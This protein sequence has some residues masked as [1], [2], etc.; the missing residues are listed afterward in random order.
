MKNRTCASIF[1]LIAFLLSACQGGTPTAAPMPVFTKM[2]FPTD[3]PSATAVPILR[4]GSGN[5][6]VT[7]IFINHTTETLKI[8]WVN[9]DGGEDAYGEV[10]PASSQ[11]NDTYNTH[12]WRVRD[13]AGNLIGEVIAS[14]DKVQAFQ[15]DADK[16]FSA[17]TYNPCKLP[18]AAATNVALGFPKMADRLRST[19]SVN[20][21]VLFVDFSD[22]QAKGKPEELFAM[23]SPGA[24]K[25]YKDISYGRMNLVLEPH[26]AW[27]R[28]SQ[29]SAH[30]GEGLNSAEG[31]QTFIQEAVDLADSEVDFS[32]ADS[33]LVMAPPQAEALTKGPAFAGSPDFGIHADGVVLANAVTSGS[34]LSFWGFLWLNHEMGHSMSLVDLYDYNWNTP[35]YEDL[36]KFVGNFGLMDAIDGKSPEY[37]A[38]ERWQ[39]GWLDDDQIACQLTNDATTTLSPIETAGNIKAVMIPVSE[40][41]VVV[42]ES[43]R[44]LGYDK[45]IVKP[46]AL[47]YTVDTS[48][49]SGQGPIVV[50]PILDSDPHRDKSPLAVGESA[51]V[52]GVTVTVLEATDNSDTVQVTVSR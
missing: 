37:F 39:L 41:K 45:A 52:D 34:D 17:T 2:P 12:V 23:V 11:Q 43:R 22:V 50:Y 15:I 6:A 4:S 1:L 18:V 25:Y 29:P 9:F 27:L 38:F 10:S 47:I 24:E 16:K 14:N 36:G 44:A 28:L 7:L 8:S 26:L 32:K 20:M 51:T 3:V 48:I 5:E 33:I 35:N 13:N 19:G 30:Y 42:V 31:H 40:T 46:G 49:A 21:I